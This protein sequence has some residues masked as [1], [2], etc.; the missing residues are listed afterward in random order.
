M[1]NIK[2]HSL[3]LLFITV[4]IL[5]VVLKDD[6]SSIMD[7]ILKMNIIF[8]F[9]SLILVTINWLFRSLSMYYIVKE[10]SNSIKFSTI[11][12]QCVIIQFFN[13]VTPFSSGGQP[14]EVY[15]LNKCKISVPKATN[16]VLQNSMVYQ[17]ALV[18]YGVIALL[19]NLKFHYF[20][21]VKI[22][23][24]LVILGF[25]VNTMVCVLIFVVSFSKKT[26]KMLLSFVTKI[27]LKLKLIK[28]K[29]EFIEKYKTKISEFHDSARIYKDNKKLFCLGIFFNFMALTLLYSVPFFLALGL[30][31]IN[32][33]PVSAI[34]SSAYTLLVGS[35]VPIP[36]GSGGIEY[37]FTQFF[38]VF[39]S[40]A[41]ISALLL[42]W[43][44][45]TYYFG[46]I[47]GGIV[48]SFYKGSEKL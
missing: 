15:L 1:K 23:R 5:Y 35:F 33:T 48:F 3:A 12:K 36:G 14:M 4:I 43:R 6:F 31:N 42:I 45:V 37:S 8:L 28:N 16:I 11:F 24:Y 20:D 27:G 17:I 46:M 13:G 19:L 10:Y 44:F 40:T 30:G 32:L 38:G 7:I 18:L 2:R 22:L 34:I 39:A 9:A 26:S 21:Q 25:V 47:L 41:S 29:Q